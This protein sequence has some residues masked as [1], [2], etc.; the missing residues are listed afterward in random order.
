M[1]ARF[2]PVAGIHLIA[3]AVD[4]EKVWLDWIVS[5]PLPGFI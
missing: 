3:T 2:S 1:F 4:A 5:V